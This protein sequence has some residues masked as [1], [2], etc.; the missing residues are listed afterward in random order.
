[1]RIDCRTVLDTVVDCH[2]ETLNEEARNAQYT[3]DALHREDER[4]A[5][6]PA[7]ITAIRQRKE[8]IE[9]LSRTKPWV[10]EFEKQGRLY[11]SPEAENDRR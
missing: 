1:M 7:V 2:G 11:L 8:L 10:L 3:L 9:K 4:R 5:H 6:D